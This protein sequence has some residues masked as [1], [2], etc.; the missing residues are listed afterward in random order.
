VALTTTTTKAVLT[1]T[2]TKGTIL[3]TTQA[4]ITTTQ[5]ATTT[6]AGQLACSTDGF[7]AYPGNCKIFYRCVF[8]TVYIYSCPTGTGW[9]QAMLTCVMKA[10]IPGCV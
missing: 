7:Y 6:S 8:G 10:S 2:T 9:S 4:P 1:T 3:T 5:A